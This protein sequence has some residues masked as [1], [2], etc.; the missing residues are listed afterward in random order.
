MIIR[1][2][3]KRQISDAGWSSLGACQN[4]YLEVG[5]S[6]PPPAIIRRRMKALFENDVKEHG[7]QNREENRQTKR[8]LLAHYVDINMVKTAAG[9]GQDYHLIGEGVES[10]SEE[11]N[12]ETETKQWINQANGNTDVKSY[13][14]NIDFDMEDVDPEDEEMQEWVNEM[15]DTLPTGSAAVTSYIRV[16]LKNPTGEGAYKAVKRMCAVSVGSTG[17]DAGANVTNS[18]SLGGKGDGIPGTFNVTTNTFTPGEPSVASQN[19]SAG[20]VSTQSADVPQKTSTK[21]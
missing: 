10:L 12:S 14:P 1:N 19:A 11:F 8:E 5:G 3:K 13:T 17:G 6:N 9:S 18:I 15:V 16:R 20:A 7:K 4:R 2:R 21:S